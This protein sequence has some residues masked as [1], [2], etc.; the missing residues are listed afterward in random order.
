[1]FCVSFRI[2]H[3]Y[4]INGIKIWSVLNGDVSVMLRSQYLLDGQIDKK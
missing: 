3:L 1:M 4:Y 2:P